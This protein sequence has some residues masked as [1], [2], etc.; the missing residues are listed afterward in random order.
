MKKSITALFI[1][2]FSAS[3][4]AQNQEVLFTVENN[5]T[6]NK[7]F[8]R[9]YNK[10]IDLVKDEKQ[11]DID[12]YLNLYINY[13]LKL[14][15]A[16]SMGLDKEPQYKRELS[17]YRNQL[18][19]KYLTDTQVSEKLLKEAYERTINE[20]N[21]NH[22]LVRVDENAKPSDTLKAYTKIK[23]L[24]DQALKEGFN[25]TMKSVHNGNTV[26][27]ESLG[28]FNAFRMV[29][30]FESAAYNTPVG[31]ISEPFRTKFGYHIVNIIDKRK[32]RG[33]VTV[34]HIMISDNNKTLTG[35][36]KERIDEL[37]K[38]LKEGSVFEDLARQFSDDKNSAKKGGKL[39]RFGAGKLNA[40]KFE[41]TAFN[42]QEEGEISKPIKT[43]FGWHIIKLLK[44]HDVPTFEEL[45][46][47][48]NRK[49]TKDSRSKII[50]A[51]FY[52]SLKNRYNFKLQ[53]NAKGNILK[54][55]N[56]NFFN[57]SLDE[58]NKVYK[59][60]MA[61]YASESISYLDYYKYLKAR[62]R[63]FKN[64]TNFENLVSE[65][66]NTYTNQQVYSY[67]DGNLENEFEDFAAI[68]Q[69]YKEGLLL[70][71]LMEKEIWKKSKT[72]TIGLK[73]YY[74]ANKSKYFW[75]KRVEAIVATTKSKKEAKKICKILKE[76][77][78]DIQ[79]IK[80]IKGVV[81]SEG[82]FEKNNREIPSKA[83]LEKGVS[84]IFRHNSQYVVLDIKRI[85]PP[86]QKE[87]D[88][89]K[90]N[91]INDYQ[92]QLEKNWLKNLREKYSVVVNE[93]M[94]KKVKKELTK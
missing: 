4:Y 5:P 30:L 92:I 72:D 68:M 9:V 26:F 94:L 35:T 18:A 46:T 64:Y 61:T 19:K 15:E 36:S 43:N 74:D 20:V 87:F 75:D 53:P 41:E 31:E 59:E 85:L 93:E 39:N 33:E 77:N 45:K 13:K 57:G 24:K 54:V 12:E 44:K 29:Y 83:K 58:N 10:N 6:T 56:K 52:K 32:S 60:V 82:M 70:F 73:K 76:T 27:G 3:L 1:I 21:A 23:E 51:K 62:S 17:S 28:Y 8:K 78:T 63:K 25:I 38:Q 40:K 84:K 7:E 50:N 66:L 86:S 81:V 69:E 2:L 89:V 11:K 88:E 79:K 55:V 14:Q 90:G 42:L 47:E 37:Y 65:S 91:V 67:H 80:D 49:I 48:L 71:E 22:I 16:I 34:A